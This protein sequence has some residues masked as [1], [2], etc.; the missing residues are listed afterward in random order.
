[1]KSIVNKTHG[2]LRV[3]LP[4]GKI[5]HLGPNKTGQVSVHDADHPPL[6]KMVEAGQIELYDR[7]NPSIPTPSSTETPF[8]RSG[9]TK[10]GAQGGFHRKAD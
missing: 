5:L 2:P 3:P 9:G 10:A 7:D 4:K 8:Q 6:Q 1:M